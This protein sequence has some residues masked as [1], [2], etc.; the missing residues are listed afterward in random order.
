MTH[1]FL[2][3]ICFDVDLSFQKSINPF[4]ILLIPNHENCKPIS[5]EMISEIL[6]DSHSNNLKFHLNFDIYKEIQNYLV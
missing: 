1:F 3:A 6:M 4:W 2:K 5:L